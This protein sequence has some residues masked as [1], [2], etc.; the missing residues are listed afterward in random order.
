MQIEHRMYLR[1][2]MEP[3]WLRPSIIL[4]S[5]NV[6]TPLS[7]LKHVPLIFVSEVL[8]SWL[9]KHTD[10]ART[11]E[12][13]LLLRYVQCYALS[14]SSFRSTKG[15]YAKPLQTFH[16]TSQTRGNLFLHFCCGFSGFGFLLQSVPHQAGFMTILNASSN[17]VVSEHPKK[18]H[19]WENSKESSRC[20]SPSQVSR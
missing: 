10:Q 12:H 5:E 8:G 14:P 16:S 15:G 6:K 11:S 19:L 3:A 4:P 9:E 2:S 13:E 7:S 1:E 18:K 17:T 20:G